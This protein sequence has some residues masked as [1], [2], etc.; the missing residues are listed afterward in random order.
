MVYC[1]EC[2]HYNGSCSN[3]KGI[4]YKK[5]IDVDLDIECIG[6]VNMEGEENTGDGDVPFMSGL[7]DEEL[8]EFMGF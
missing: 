4:L 5:K 1:Y 6:Y 8:G 7:A 2:G 3:P